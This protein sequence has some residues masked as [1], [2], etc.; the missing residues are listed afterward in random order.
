M[1]VRRVAGWSGSRAPRASA[2]DQSPSLEGI[3]VTSKHHTKAYCT[4]LE[5]DASPTGVAIK[6]YTHSREDRFLAVGWLYLDQRTL[7]HYLRSIHAE[8][9]LSEQPMLPPWD[10]EGS[11]NVK[12]LPP[13]P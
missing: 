12:W 3:H 13:Q 9:E 11:E 6:L 10:Q 8:R 4:V 2:S 5:T 1:L 7:E